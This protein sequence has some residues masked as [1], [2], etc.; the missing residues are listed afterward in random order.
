[1]ETS[2]GLAT[3]ARGES[4]ASAR[5]D[6]EAWISFGAVLLLL[7][8]FYGFVAHF[9]SDKSITAVGGW[10]AAWNSENDFEHGW[11]FPPLVVILLGWRRSEILAARTSGGWCGLA[12]ALI[13]AALFV[14]AYRTI[15]WRLAIIGLPFVLTGAVW[16]AWGWRSALLVAFPFFLTWLAIPVAFLQQA[17][18]GLQ[19]I[20]TK[21]AHM[22]SSLF[23]VQTTIRG[24]IL[25]MGDGTGFAVD[26]GCSGIRSLWALLLIAS[27]WAYLAKLPLWKKAVLLLSVFPIAILGN[28]LRLVSIFII[29]EFGNSKF[30][31]GTW[32]D[33]S[34]LVLFYPIS[35]FILL[36]VHSLLEGG[37]PWK[38]EKRR[39]VRRVVT[40]T[41][42]TPA[43]TP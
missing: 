13:G 43:E 30:A 23:G 11:I 6:L 25:T 28:A 22:G 16:Y 40:R 14:L 10:T 36:G 2:D 20:A 34:P 12:F 19:L 1:M 15:Q 31:S 5:K 37:L 21:L 42:V 33:W 41:T 8:Y 7:T 39:E 27:A 17:T 4:P 18:G 38:K 9:G 26:E 35:L 3:T 32:H 24:N 29:A